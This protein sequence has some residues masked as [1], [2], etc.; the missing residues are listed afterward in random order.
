MQKM[1]RKMREY[2]EEKA[3]RF[4]ADV[5]R[6]RSRRE[7]AEGVAGDMAS[8]I[9]EAELPHFRGDMALVYGCLWYARDHGVTVMFSAPPLPAR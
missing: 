9:V 2:V 4:V 1:P 7:E 3:P 5:E 6:A 8:P